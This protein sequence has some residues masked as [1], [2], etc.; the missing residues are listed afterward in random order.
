MLLVNLRNLESQHQIRIVFKGNS[1]LTKVT[2][3]KADSINITKII[4]QQ[5]TL[6]T[7]LRREP[8]W[9]FM[10]IKW[11]KSKRMTKH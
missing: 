7:D 10:I 9:V 5:Q 1:N 8:R 11:N 6:W 4:N 3:I 2:L